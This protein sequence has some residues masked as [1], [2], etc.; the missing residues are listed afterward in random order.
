MGIT[1]RKERERESR[2][3]SIIDAA[4]KVFFDKGLQLSTMDEI[5]DTAELAKGTLYL[6]YHSKEDLYL[7]VMMRGLMILKAM[8]DD[9]IERRLPVVP[10][11]VEL[12][13]TYTEF[14]RTN[15]NYFR[16]MHFFNTPQLHKQ[17]SESMMHSCDLLNQKLWTTITGIIERG[18]KEGLVNAGLDPI[19]IAIIMWTNASS[20]MMRIDS[21]HE[22]FLTKLNI[23]LNSTLQKSNMLL[24]ES[25]MTE[26]GKNELSLA[27]S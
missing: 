4:Q 23:D 11:L 10:M 24:L 3:E 19:E 14:Y 2:R 20:L 22:M 16:M 1:E 13:K 18:M 9:V 6:Y 25:V 12:T 7:A 21:Q 17:V 26:R 5:A 27:L 8:F 15:K